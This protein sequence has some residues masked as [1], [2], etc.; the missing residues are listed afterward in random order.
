M[1]AGHYLHAKLS[2]RVQEVRRDSPL[3]SDIGKKWI[4]GSTT[5]IRVNYGFT[6]KVNFGSSAKVIEANPRDLPLS[7]SAT[8]MPLPAG[9][10]EHMDRRYA[11]GIIG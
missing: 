2:N 9:E 6:L 10:L 3:V 8:C 5:D 7:D 4:D 1:K 11:C